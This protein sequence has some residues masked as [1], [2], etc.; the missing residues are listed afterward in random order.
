M[1]V[2]TELKICELR[3]L[4]W[5]PFNKLVELLKLI[6]KALDRELLGLLRRIAHKLHKIIAI[7]FG[8]VDRNEGSHQ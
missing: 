5:H 1:K 6:V 3:F 2:L 7:L 4:A 8:G